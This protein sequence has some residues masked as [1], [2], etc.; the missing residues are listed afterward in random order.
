MSPLIA[1][2]AARID[3]YLRR[4]G[5]APSTFGRQ[6]AG[7]SMFL[8]RLKDGKATLTTL[9][10]VVEWLD[11]QEGVAKPKKRKAA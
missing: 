5:M 11:W 8:S 3:A 2:L 4:T 6:A 1:P 9:D 10:Q 7:N